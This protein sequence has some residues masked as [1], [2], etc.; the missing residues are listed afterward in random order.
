MNLADCFR[1]VTFYLSFHKL[2]KGRLDLILIHHFGKN[3]ILKMRNESEFYFSL[4]PK[5]VA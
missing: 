2:D 3:A 1:L 5:A 4:S